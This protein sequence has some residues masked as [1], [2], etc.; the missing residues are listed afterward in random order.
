MTNKDDDTED[1]E[2][3]AIAMAVRVAR[4]TLQACKVGATN[5]NI[6][7]ARAL[8]RDGD[9]GSTALAAINKELRQFVVEY[10]VCEP[11]CGHVENFHMS[12]ALY[13]ELKDKARLV[14][15]KKIRDLIIDYG[16]ETNSPTLNGKL[17]NVM[18][19]T[20]IHEKLE[21]EVWDVKGA[22]LKAPMHTPG[23]YVMLAKDIVTKMLALLES[24][25]K[26]KHKLWE[27]AVKPDGRLIV[28][29]KK[30]WYGLA[31]SSMLWHKEISDT[32]VNVAGYTQHPLEQCLYS[33][34]SGDKSHSY[35]ML[36]VDDLGV[37]MKPGDP[38][39]DRLK[40]I[41]EEKY[42]ALKIQRGDK[43]KY[44]GFEILRNRD[45]NRFELTMT[46]YIN[47]MCTQYNIGSSSNRIVRNP[48]TSED[49]AAAVYEKEEDNKPYEQI[50]VYR[51]LVMS[52]QYGTLVLPSIKYHV[53]LLATRQVAPKC[54]DFKKAQRVLEY[55]R[56][57]A[58]KP[59]YIYGFGEDPDIYVYADAAFDVYPDSH[60]HGGLSVFIGTAGG[61]MHNSSNKQKCITESSTGAE[62]VSAVNGLSIGAYYRDILKEFGYKCRVIHYEDNMSCIALV[63]TGCV[64][65]DKKQRHMV[66]KINIMHEYFEDVEN[67][68]MMLWCD[69]AWM[70][71]DGLTKDLHG[72]AFE[73][74]ED[75]LMGHPLGDTGDYG[76]RRNKND[77]V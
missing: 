42:E 73:I 37:M 57:R 46:D 70:I 13:D 8:G 3:D 54:G 1:T 23:V 12:H 25:D 75:V 55:M 24:E 68:A 69:T 66:R 36:H 20:C 52:M 71:A 72:Q 16:V 28:E 19:S 38:E 35:V 67:N 47:R 61:A 59:V 26:E 14:V 15:G 77:T 22:F 6:S 50:A 17:V 48:A 7:W 34:V 56:Y 32:L 9:L 43:V 45:M 4:A 27:A 53:I 18:L 62:V 10:D 39:R 44:I 30:G 40:D 60:S 51:S 76:V 33:R 65:H 2:P 64:A 41:L 58:Q 31:C 63:D 29:V 74:S 49:F 11:V 21:L 5:K